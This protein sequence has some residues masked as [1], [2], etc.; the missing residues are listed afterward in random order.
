MISLMF[1]NY[2][3]DRSSRSQMLFKIGA[4]KYFAIFTWK[5]VLKTSFLIK[6]QASGNFIKRETPT[7]VFSCE[8]FEIFR[9]SSFI[10]SHRWLFLLWSVPTQDPCYCQRLKVYEL[11]LTCLW[12]TFIPGQK[13][14]FIFSLIWP[15]LALKIHLNLCLVSR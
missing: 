5:H 7:H 2:F 15:I 11:S 8:Y 6:L 3:C 12:N 14:E 4:V 10:E 1:L 13:S 9:K